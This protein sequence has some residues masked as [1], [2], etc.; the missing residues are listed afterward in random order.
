M[1]LVISLLIPLIVF[2]LV[3]LR[4]VPPLVGLV[5][6]V[7]LV[8]EGT[9]VIGIVILIVSVLVIYQNVIR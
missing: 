8:L 3:V 1:S 7:V 6:G 9:P 5:A 4:V 2:Y